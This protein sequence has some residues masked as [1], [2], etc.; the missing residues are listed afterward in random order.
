M[1][2]SKSLWLLISTSAALIGFAIVTS[3]ATYLLLQLMN[4]LTLFR[5]NK[6][7]H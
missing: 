6:N 1:K 3:N 7:M 4:I 2:T 5:L